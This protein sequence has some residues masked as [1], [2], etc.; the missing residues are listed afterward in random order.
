MP[1]PRSA[2]SAKSKSR[3]T[4]GAT[5]KYSASAAMIAALPYTQTVAGRI[6]VPLIASSIPSP[7]FHRATGDA[8]FLLRHRKWSQGGRVNS[9]RHRFLLGVLR[10]TPELGERRAVPSAEVAEEEVKTSYG[11][12]LRPIR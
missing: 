10:R 4:T 8:T 6:R 5:K 3:I 11:H 2:G 9:R 1:G 7:G 12:T